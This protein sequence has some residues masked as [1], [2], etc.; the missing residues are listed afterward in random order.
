MEQAVI[1]VATNTPMKLVDF[2]LYQPM[3]DLGVNYFMSTYVGEDPTV[4][5]LFYLP[6]FYAKT[7]YSN[8]ALQQSITAAGLAGYA[9]TARQKEVSNAALKRYVQAIQA[10]NT[11]LSDSK[12]A[13]HDSTLLAIMMLSMF[14]VLIMPRMSDM[15]NCAKHLVGAVSYAL[16]MLQHKKPGE[17]TLRII[18][19]LTQSVIIS[20]WISH[21]PLPPNFVELKTELDKHFVPISIHGRFLDIVMELNHFRQALQLGTYKQPT[22]IIKHALAIDNSL[23]RFSNTMPPHAIFEAVWLTGQVAEKLAYRGYYHRKTW[24]RNAFLR[25]YQLIGDE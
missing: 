2:V 9:K 22:D 17:V 10:I 11:A 12:S 5:Q 18:T 3:A 7:G 1:S 20:T 24:H 25:M 14:E 15:Q 6:N 23:D 4:S 21:T 13:M 8:P 16:L 19:T